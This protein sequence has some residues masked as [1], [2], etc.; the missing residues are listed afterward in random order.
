M[1]NLQT[2]KECEKCLS[3]INLTFKFNK[4]LCRDCY[5]N[6]MDNNEVLKK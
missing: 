3:T 4:I 1:N 2:I 5:F 6:E